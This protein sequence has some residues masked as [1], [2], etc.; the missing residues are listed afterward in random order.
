MKNTSGYTVESIVKGLTGLKL[1]LSRTLSDLSDKLTSEANKLGDIQEAIKIETKNLEEIH[2]IKIAAETLD[3]LINTHE[4]KKKAFEEEVTMMRAQFEKEKEDNQMSVKERDEK[5]KKEREREA[6][7]YNYNLT[8]LRKKE[9]DAYEEEKAALK[10]AL[11]EERKAQE[12]ELTGREAAVASQEK[13]IAELR[14]KVLSF[15]DDLKK[16]AENAKKEAVELSEN[17]AKQKADL[18]A[19]EIEGDKK[20]AELKIKNLED[21]TARQAA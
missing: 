18:L 13:E 21:I 12:N 4:D 16:A 14:N 11:K 15:P 1:D 20:L 8:M 19:K 17:R 2:G 6:E 7:E 10:K 5:V 9:K 3:N